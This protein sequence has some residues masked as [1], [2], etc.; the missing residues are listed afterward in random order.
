MSIHIF[1]LG[2]FIHEVIFTGLITVLGVVVMWPFKK[3]KAAFKGVQDELKAAHA[4]LVLQRENCLSTL[5]RQ[6]VDQVN[7]LTKVSETLDGVRIELATQTGFLRAG[8]VPTR[9]RVK[10]T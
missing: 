9:R 5:Q 4:E 3:G 2:E 8:S 7:L 6:G 1:V 10:K